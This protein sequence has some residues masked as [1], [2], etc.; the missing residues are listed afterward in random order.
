MKLG[1]LIVLVAACNARL[2]EPVGSH[3]VGADSG[4]D[5]MPLL[6]DAGPDARGCTGGDSHATDSDGNCYL[7]FAGPKTFP[8]AKTACAAVPAHQVKITSASQNAVVAQLSLGSDAFIG[9]TDA[10]TEG[11]FLWD[12]GTPLTFTM[13]GTGEPNNGSGVYEEDCLVMAGKR[14]PADTWD[15]RP[16]TT[17]IVANAGSYS[18]VC[19]Y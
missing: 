12:D 9:A 8:Q 11:T 18:Y 4:V 13:F 10:V 14:T 15:D 2:G 16:C 1:I 19:E 7:F 6:I 3:I 5:S 17:G